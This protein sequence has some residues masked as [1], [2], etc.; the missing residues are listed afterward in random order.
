[1]LS[2]QL[3]SSKK[4]LIFLHK[5]ERIK[6]ICFVQSHA[7]SP[8]NCPCSRFSECCLISCQALGEGQ[9]PLLARSLLLE[10]GTE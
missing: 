10:K 5:S 8:G 6:Q 9:G 3:V 7:F 1:M 2:S 4:T